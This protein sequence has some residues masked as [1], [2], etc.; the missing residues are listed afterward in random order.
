MMNKNISRRENKKVVLSHTVLS[1]H[2]KWEGD[3]LFKRSWKTSLRKHAVV[4]AGTVLPR[5]CTRAPYVTPIN[6]IKHV[7]VILILRRGH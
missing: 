3:S 5:H 6:L 1:L 2:G 4:D 7:A